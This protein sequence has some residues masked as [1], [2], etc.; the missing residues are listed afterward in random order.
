MHALELKVPPPAFVLFI[1]LLMGLISWTV[2]QFGFDFHRRVP[3]AVVLALAGT[4]ISVLG[5]AAFKRAKTT[6]NPMNPESTTSIVVSGVYKISRNPMYLGLLLILGGWA[7]YLSNWLAFLL[8]PI[9]VI[10]LN[11]FQIEPEERALRSKF[12]EE[13]RAYESR[14]R[15]WL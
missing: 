12:R 15:R 14:V 9:F 10:Y 2:P 8:L 1:A 6:V 4:I 11:R 3:I 5:V 7:V 13:F